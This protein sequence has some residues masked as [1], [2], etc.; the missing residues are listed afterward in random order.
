M[1]EMKEWTVMFYLATDNP[2]AP[3]AVMHL[4]A[5]QNAGYHPEVNVLA[6]F[7]PRGRNMP[8]Q[9]FDVNR[10]EKLKNPGRVNI[11][12]PNDFY[13]RNIVADKLWDDEE[14]SR[15]KTLMKGRINYD[16][17]PVPTN[18]LTKRE[19]S[20]EES[21][22]LFL[23]FCQQEYPARHYMLFLLGHGL[24]VA[25]D[26]FL[27]DENGSDKKGRSEPR[28]LSLQQLGDVLEGFNGAIK[29]QD[30]GK[31]A[32]ELIGF[33][34]C[35][36]SGAEVAFEL[37]D[38]VKYMLASQG[39]AYVGIW[40]YRQILMRLFSDLARA[41]FSK[42]D[43]ETNG[44]LPGSLEGNGA[45]EMHVAGAASQASLVNK[46]GNKFHSV[47]THSKPINK[48]PLSSPDAVQNGRARTTQTAYTNANIKNL[49]ISIFN[50][51]YFNSLD[52]QLAGYSTDLTLC[53]LRKMDRLNNPVEN[54]ATALTNGLKARSN[55]KH[56]QVRDLLVLAHWESQS[57]F[58]ENY[59]DLYDFCFCLKRRCEKA[60]PAKK[61]PQSIQDIIDACDDTMEQLKRGSEKDC[62]GIIVR[63]ECV[64]PTY[65]YA[66][67]LSVYFPWA[68][69][70]DNKTWPEE[71]SEF[72]FNRATKWKK[73]L[74]LY[75]AETQ[76]KPQEAEKDPRDS[77]SLPH[78]L[79]KDMREFLEEISS[80]SVFND[81]P[82]LM[83]GARDMLGPGKA[84]SLDPM[85]SGC[86]CGSIKN[87]PRIA[88]GDT[89]PR[90][91]FKGYR[92]MAS[93][94]QSFLRSFPKREP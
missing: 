50:Y 69:P 57:Y 43:L 5:M 15:I 9:I 76:R 54:L 18:D 33:H 28:S 58:E 10:M 1:Y 75:F 42:D 11:G 49:A 61:K 60:Y 86:D 41:G 91:R 24:I 55:G 46:F 81:D 26:M 8:V 30:Q 16:E 72:R 2:L 27:Y 21:L 32:L 6:Q 40:P 13:V 23:E 88:R 53:D 4:K 85:G 12:F 65:Q 25:G 94:Y 87:H 19:N 52:Y 77:C 92:L 71:Y 44:H 7:D 78:N 17:V 74:E 82:Q 51:C 3:G 48:T 83:V 90:I 47:L 45:G 66:H 39:S 59:T 35:S 93:M 84:G 62:E 89:K 29:Q 70:V 37:K 22:R 73:F 34:S 68:E 79:D 56:T 36:M 38:K 31:G 20:P 67:G 64:G 63:C 14:N 80:R